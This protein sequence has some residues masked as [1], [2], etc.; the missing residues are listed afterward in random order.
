MGRFTGGVKG[1]NLNPDDNVVGVETPRPGADLLTVCENGYGKRSKV[2]DYRLTNRGGKGVINIK[3]T[4]RNGKVVAIKEVIDE[5]ELIMI[6]REGM[7][8]RSRVADTR[9]ISRNTQGVRLINLQKKDDKVVGVARLAE[10]EEEDG[11]EI[12]AEA[13]MDGVEGENI[14]ERGEDLEPGDDAGTDETPDD[15]TT[16]DDITED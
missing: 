13:I 6:T 11:D 3:A 12:E 7:S 9:T 10:K 14:I 4:D 5:D 8:I 1:I 2:D 15:D 16:D